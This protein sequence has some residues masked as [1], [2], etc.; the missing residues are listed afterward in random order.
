MAAA[1]RTTVL[2]VLVAALLLLYPL[3]ASSLDPPSPADYGAMPAAQKADVLWDLI[4]AN[5][6][7]GSFMSLTET[8]KIAG[9]CPYLQLMQSVQLDWREVGHRKIS[10]GIGAHARAHIRWLP[11]EYTGMYQEAYHCLVRLANPA[12]PGKWTFPFTSYGPNLAIKCLNDGPTSV[13]LQALWQ[14]DG[15]SVYPKGKKWSCSYFEAPLASH[16]PRRYD[17]LCKACPG[18]FHGGGLIPLFDKADNQS[19]LIGTSQLAEVRQNGEKETETLRFPFALMFVPSSPSHNEVPCSFNNFTSQ[20]LDGS[21]FRNGTVLYDIHA[22]DTP[23]SERPNG[24]PSMNKIGEVVLESNFVKSTFG[25]TRLFFRHTF[26]NEE[27]ASVAD[28]K[29]RE[30][31]QKYVDNVEFGKTEGAMLYEPFL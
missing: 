16:T 8:G 29:E 20:L 21:H 30:I 7:G 1:L 10:H 24:K 28:P 22:I 31:W 4:T 17:L 12:K 25:D 15:Y 9:S 27:I 5:Q 14:L 6:T 23:W 18:F 11:N 3:A 2:N 26:F 13:N 19:M